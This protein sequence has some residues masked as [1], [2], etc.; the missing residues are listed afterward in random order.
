MISNNLPTSLG[1]AILLFGKFWKPHSARLPSYLHM[2]NPAILF[3]V[4][5]LALWTVLVLMQIPIARFRSA[6][7]REIVADDLKC[8][9]SS[10]VPAH[11]SIPNRNYMNLLELP[12]LFYVA[13]L[14]IYTTDVT[15]PTM[16]A[17]AWL[18]VG[19]RVVHSLIHLS[20]ND[21]LHRLAA[22]AASN[23]VLVVLWILAAIEVFSRPSV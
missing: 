3:P 21:V 6:R 17:V 2:H 11:V 7:R 22:F 1:S 13:C 12:V 23:L 8:G 18:Y 10:S 4:F 19:L 16:I 14:L 9:E 20:Y 15:S 5:A